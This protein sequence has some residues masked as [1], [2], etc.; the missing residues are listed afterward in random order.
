MPERLAALLVGLG[1][2]VARSGA[3][4]VAVESAF[5]GISAR[6][7]LALGQARGVALAVAA[8]AGL[9]IFEYAPAEV[10]LAFTGNGRA[11]KDQMMRMAQALFG[12]RFERSDEADALALAVCHLARR[13]S[14]IQTHP[15]IRPTSRT[16]KLRSSRRRPEAG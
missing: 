12:V 11:E 15:A 10:K 5:F 16:P 4:E 7:A 3:E 14:H 9:Q 8:R 6:S 13:N 2:V 1:E